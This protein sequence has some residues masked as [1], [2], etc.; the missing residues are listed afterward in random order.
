V[1]RSRG[2]DVPDFLAAGP[3]DVL[4]PEGGA[5]AARDMLAGSERPPGSSPAVTA[6]P[7]Q[8]VVAGL[9]IGVAVLAVIAWL[10]SMA[11]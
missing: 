5:E 7:P 8:N 11:A 4:V 9:L 3:R 1:R 10:V 2:F 6:V